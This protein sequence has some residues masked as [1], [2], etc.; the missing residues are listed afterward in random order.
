MASAVG[1][2]SSLTLLQ[3]ARRICEEVNRKVT[4]SRT[5]LGEDNPLLCERG[6]ENCESSLI[7]KVGRE[8]FGVWKTHLNK[9]SVIRLLVWKN[10]EIED[11]YSSLMKIMAVARAGV[12]ESEEIAA[13]ALER[14][15]RVYAIALFIIIDGQDSLE[16]DPQH[17]KPAE[18]HGFV[19]LAPSTLKKEIASAIDCSDQCLPT[20]FLKR[21]PPE[22]VIIDPFFKVVCTCSE[23]ESKAEKLLSHVARA[24]LTRMLSVFAF[25]AESFELERVIENAGVVY[26]ESGA[27]ALVESVSSFIA[28]RSSGAA[29]RP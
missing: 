18:S 3:E 20:E 24:N 8:R 13:A 25:Q 21:L 12:G 19:I 29:A 17:P 1:P 15:R 5:I 7:D 23:H 28:S 27:E 22:A 6:S 4:T 14:A 16:G 26:R 10:V 2:A 9:Y 11:K